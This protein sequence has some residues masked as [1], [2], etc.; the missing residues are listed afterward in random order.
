MACDLP[1]SNHSL[2]KGVFMT[3]ILIAVYTL[4][5]VGFLLYAGFIDDEDFIVFAIFWP[6][7]LPFLLGLLIVRAIYEF[8][9]RFNR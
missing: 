3:Y 9:W 2:Y 6:I 4:G 5:L 8:G 1:K 7:F